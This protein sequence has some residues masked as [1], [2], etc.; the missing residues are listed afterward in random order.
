MEDTKKCSKCRK[1]FLLTDFNVKQNGKTN[2]MCNGCIDLC[3]QYKRTKT[4]Y[5]NRIPDVDMDD[6]TEDDTSRKYIKSLQA[7]HE[8]LYNEALKTHSYAHE[9]LSKALDDYNGARMRFELSEVSLSATIKK[10]EAERD[11][12]KENIAI[13][14]EIF[15][16]L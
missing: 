4:A 5:N 14:K 2:K 13:C 7:N 12:Q 11:L 16:T 3:K 15:S 9:Q 1:T 6:S 8:K 10:A